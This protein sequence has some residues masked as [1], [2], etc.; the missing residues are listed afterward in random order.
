[1]S[2]LIKDGE[3]NIDL[4]DDVVGPSCVSHQGNW[5]NQRVA[6]ALKPAR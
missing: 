5:V 6:A 4:N 1:M 2:L 3:L